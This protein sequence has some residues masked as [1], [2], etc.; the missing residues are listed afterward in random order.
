MK[1]QSISIAGVALLLFACGASAQATSIAGASQAPSL[2]ASDSGGRG[3]GAEAVPAPG[4]LFKN[5]NFFRDAKF[6]LDGK[7]YDSVF[8]G[9]VLEHALAPMPSAAR[10]YRSARSTHNAAYMIAFV[11]GA[12]MGVA[13]GWGIVGG[14]GWTTTN[15]G[16]LVGGVAVSAG[17]LFLDASAQGRAGRAVEEFNSRT[18]P[19]ISFHLG[20]TGGVPLGGIQLNF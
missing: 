5:G 15:T 1:R 2:A 13:V 3:S 12:A 10:E 9:S 11:G 18:A 6:S 8:E 16:L 14:R 4:I 17:G 7:N 20:A 19:R